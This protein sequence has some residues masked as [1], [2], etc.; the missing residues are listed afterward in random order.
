MHHSRQAVHEEALPDDQ[1]MH[2]DAKRLLLLVL[3]RSLPEEKELFLAVAPGIPKNLPCGFPT[4]IVI[5]SMAS[6]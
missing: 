3:L 4:G 1:K 6:G 5:L 2:R